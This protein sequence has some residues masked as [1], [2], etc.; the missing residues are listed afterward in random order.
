MDIIRADSGSITLF[1]EPMSRDQLDRLGY[2]PEERGLYTKQ[3][4]LNVMTYFG[5]LKGLD[6]AEAR[7]RSR[8]WLERVGLSE[9]ASWRVERL[10]KGMSQKVQI[11]STLPPHPGLCGPGRAVS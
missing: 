3:P 1:G 7:R 8:E 10:S 4:V 2:L 9:V 5:T 11:A 6:R